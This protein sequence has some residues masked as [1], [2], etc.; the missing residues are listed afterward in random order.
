[1]RLPRGRWYDTVTGLAYEGPGQILLDAPADRIPVLARAGSLLPVRA[2]DGSVALEAW[3]PAR[4]RT[5]GGVV[6][7][8]PGPGFEPVEVERY[9]VR[10]AGDAVVVEDEAGERVDGVVLRGL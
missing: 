9:V 6:I 1:M 3:A 10:W 5:G 4:G 8:D 7:R 2:A